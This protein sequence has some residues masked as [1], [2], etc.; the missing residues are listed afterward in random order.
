MH[1]IWTKNHNS[2]LQRE[3]PNYI[4]EIMHL[5]DLV[6]FVGFLIFKICQQLGVVPSHPCICNLVPN[7]E[8]RLEKFWYGRMRQ[9][10]QV[11]RDQQVVD[12]SY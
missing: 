4:H 3:K 1:L 12:N 5:Y 9:S 10:F 8:T 2:H 6:K 11:Q 7:L